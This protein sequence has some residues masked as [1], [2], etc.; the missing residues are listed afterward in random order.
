MFGIKV[1]IKHAIYYPVFKSKKVY[2]FFSTW[3]SSSCIYCWIKFTGDM[4]YLFFKWSM[5][6]ITIF[7][8]TLQATYICHRLSD[9]K[10]SGNCGCRSKHDCRCIWWKGN[11]HIEESL[12]LELKWKFDYTNNEI[13][14]YIRKILLYIIDIYLTTINVW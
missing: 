14:I 3:R 9:N 11:P 2:G 5:V 8:I 7:F 10:F 12:M 1:Y 4:K 13:K 6:S